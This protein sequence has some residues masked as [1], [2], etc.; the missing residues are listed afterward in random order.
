ISLNANQLQLATSLANANAGTAITLTAN[1][2][3]GIP[4]PPLTTV[5]GSLTR[6]AELAASAPGEIPE[7]DNLFYV[8]NSTP[9]NPFTSSG[10]SIGIAKTPGGTALKLITP[11]ELAS[12]GASSGGR[13]TIEEQPAADLT[14]VGQVSGRLRF[15]LNNSNIGTSASLNTLAFAQ[16]S[17]AVLSAGDGNFSVSASASSGALIAAISG[18]RTDLTVTADINTSIGSNTSITTQ[19]DVI[20]N[21]VSLL[22]GEASARSGGGALL[23]ALGNSSVTANV[24]NQ[25]NTF[26]GS[27]AQ[28]SAGRNVSI[29]GESGQNI[30][31][32]GTSFAGSIL[33]P[34]TTTDID[35][36][37]DQDTISSINDGA[38]I[39][40][41][42]N[43]TVRSSESTTGSAKAVADG[44]GFVP[45]P[46]ASSRVDFDG[47]TR[48]NI[49]ANTTLEASTITLEA[50]N[51]KLDVVAD[52]RSES[53][54]FFNDTDADAT[55]DLKTSDAI[56]NFGDNA[57]ITGNFVDFR[58]AFEVVNAKAT[59]FAKNLG[60]SGDTDSDA[61]T[62]GKLDSNVITSSSSTIEAI[63]VNV[64]TD[65]GTFN[66]AANAIRKPSFELRIPLLF[67][68]LVITTDFGSSSSGR[69][70]TTSAPITFNSKVNSIL[71]D[72]NPFLT[73]DAEGNVIDSIGNTI[74]LT[75]ANDPNRRNLGL[76]VTESGNQFIIGDISNNRSGDAIT[77][78]QDGVI[79][80][81]MPTTSVRPSFDTV[82]I[83]NF[84]NRDLVINDIKAIASVTKGLPIDPTV[85]T[86][87]NFGGS[88]LI[89]EGEIYNPYSSTTIL[90]EGNIFS[91][92]T[93][94]SI[95][96]RDLTLTAA[97]NIGQEQQRIAATLIQE[98]R[99]N[100]TSVAAPPITSLNA[101]AIN[102]LFL[103]LDAKVHE[104]N[105]P[106]YTP[107]LF[108]VASL[109]AIT[110]E[111]NLKL[112]STTN[113]TGDNFASSFDFSNI[114]A[115]TGVT[116]DAGTSDI[117]IEANTN[118]LS[119]GFLD[120]ATGGS[121]QIVEAGG[122]INLRRAISQNKS[123]SLSIADISGGGDDLII[124]DNAV[125]RAA[126]NVN[127]F[128]GD[129]IQLNASAQI[130]AGGNV[131]LQGD[132]TN[133]DFEGTVIN[134]LGSIESAATFLIGNDDQDTFNIGRISSPTSVQ[135]LGGNDLFAITLSENTSNSI[136]IIGGSGDDTTIVNG[137][138]SNETFNLNR[139]Q[140]EVVGRS[141]I[142]FDTIE[143]LTVN[144]QDGNDTFNVSAV[145]SELSVNL[146]GNSGDDTFNLGNSAQSL[147]Q[148]LG[149][150]AIN[151][152]AGT[153]SLTLNNQGVN[154]NS[155]GAITANTVTGFGL[156]QGINYQ[157]LEALTLNL[158][159]GADIVT[160][161]NTHAG[162][163]TINTADGDDRVTVNGI[164]GFTLINAGLG[165][166]QLISPLSPLPTA[167]T[168]EDPD[169]DGSGGGDSGGGTS[170]ERVPT[171]RGDSTSS[172]STPSTPPT[173]S[174]RVPT[175]RGSR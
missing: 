93:D 34:I 69:D 113:L 53:I 9:A 115:Q 94:Q 22:Q 175:G 35:V 107:G 124:V 148:I 55:V 56:V 90:S 121:L 20:I 112:G 161:E 164:G 45:I 92:G 38:T 81:R 82:Q 18:S 32:S 152:N 57:K 131:V 60:F 36:S 145:E 102:S 101:L 138:S 39:V 14:G 130:I 49:N 50:I 141:I 59:S 15:D 168:F 5:T 167:L 165:N 4:T 74:D 133:Q 163:T 52:S 48:T 96:S 159:S 24:T 25:V 91:R 119:T 75:N 71:R 64:A 86:I 77:L 17:V 88:D 47:S 151:G 1:L 63:E 80:T 7:A 19:G 140:L 2:P 103:N 76:T 31:A 153:D 42:G 160:V 97:G 137:S 83:R 84:S 116:I 26:V 128:I 16:P 108:E 114:I 51:T 147:S 13:F 174:G 3:T 23:G 127:F 123:I 158:G 134:V 62:R 37:I 46:T 156:G 98:F 109:S 135:G 99:P 33:L 73:I 68:T 79:T 132:A 27:G 100:I 54:G 118:I 78:N 111:V 28:I 43:I 106:A 10:G 12:L 29:T 144:G 125:V 95:V 41:G 146:S 61:F 8:V 65:F 126:Q 85:I 110:G 129:N 66:Q 89:F 162:S 117:D 155:Q 6:L 40:A 136:N 149:A 173:S 104:Y 150:L 172:G 21:S 120:V 72:V 70:I 139:Q 143:N 30:K 11:N 170:S 157:T 166:D 154:T 142:G 44:I 105:N 169:R 171:G 87:E 67:F 122:G 58:S